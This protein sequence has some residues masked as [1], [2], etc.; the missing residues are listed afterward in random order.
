M[1][2]DGFSLHPLIAELNDKIAGGRIDRI[3]QP[4]K[5]DIYLYIRQPGQTY[6]LYLSINPQNPMVN[7]TEIQPENPP[8]PP[9]FCMVLRKQIEG[10]RIASISQYGLDRMILIDIDTLGTKGVIITKTLVAELM[11]KYS[12]LIL[13]QD[14]TIV[15]AFRKVGENNNRVRTVLPGHEYEL[16]PAQDEINILTNSTDKFVNR[17]KIYQEATLYKAILASGLGFG[18]VTVKELIYMAGLYDDL[19]VKNME[20]IDFTSLSHAVDELKSVYNEKTF[21]PVMILD[22]RNKIKAMTP[23]SLHIFPEKQFI[24]K[25]YTSLNELLEDSKKFVKR[26]T[27]PEKDVYKKII[28]AE[29][30]RQ[31]KKEKILTED[32]HKA[33]KADKQKIKADNLM[34]YQYQFQDHHDN[35]ISVPDIYDENGTVIKIALDTKLT[36][37]QNAQAYYKKYDKLKR[38]KEMIETQLKHCQRDR[39]YAMSIENALEASNSLSDLEDIKNEMIKA[40][41]LQP[42]NRKKAATP[43]SKPFKF[44]LPNNMTIYVGKN[45]YQNDRLTFKLSHKDDIWLHTK[46]IPGSHVIID[47]KGDDIDEHNLLLA[48]QIAVHFSKARNS[49]KVPVDYV[50]IKFVKKPSGSKPGFVIFTNNKTLYVTPNE[51]EII[52]IIDNDLNRK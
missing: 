49:S 26:N 11:G 17:V 36:L 50:P 45:N 19:P 10:G 21:S 12:N 38:S 37:M 41:F 3:C 27:F 40:E 47:T 34:T 22:E 43:P 9:T 52:P 13:T 4:N 31:N 39:N 29:I 23:F 35:E 44:L 1:S 24:R 28:T 16:P 30:N 18:P 51:A 6:I 33:Q 46:D 8:E 2:L 20:D 14:G 7:L 5:Q 15:D 32:F 25:K 42:D 48:A